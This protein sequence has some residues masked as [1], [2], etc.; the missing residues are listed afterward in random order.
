[1][2]WQ[3]WS[4]SS[5]IAGTR[6]VES[7]NK[8]SSNP[9]NPKSARTQIKVKLKTD[10]IMIIY[11]EHIHT[12]KK[13]DWILRLVSEKP[14]IKFNHA[15]SEDCWMISGKL[16][17]NRSQY[18]SVK[19]KL[20]SNAV[21]LSR[22]T[23]YI[24]YIWLRCREK[25]DFWLVNNKRHALS[26]LAGEG[27]VYS[28][29]T[30]LV[31]SRLV[32]VTSVPILPETGNFAQNAF[33]PRRPGWWMKLM[34]CTGRGSRARWHLAAMHNAHKQEQQSN[35]LPQH[36]PILITDSKLHFWKRHSVKSTGSILTVCSSR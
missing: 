35:P 33:L 23:V 18:M 11:C 15:V 20:P 12:Q 16:A 7:Q 1:M 29:K 19:R 36:L 21:F 30:G 9:P 10:H 6:S 4:F 31:D 22:K 24:W 27:T 3:G 14:M 26:L 8:N 25:W 13:Q 34:N 28:S 32:L 2:A 17:T 5:V